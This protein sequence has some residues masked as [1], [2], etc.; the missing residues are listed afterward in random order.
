MTPLIT[1]F[2][3]PKPSTG[4]IAVLQTNAVSS[5]RRLGQHVV[6]Y[7]DEAGVAELAASTDAEHVPE[8]T[9]NEHDTPL[10]DGI[11]EDAQARARSPIVCFANAD[12][13]L[14]PEFSSA[15]ARVSTRSR[16]FL[17]IG[18]S[19]DTDV[20]ELVDF[21]TEW[22]QGLLARP[23]RR[24]GAGA[25]DYFAFTR[26]L[27]DRLPPF[28]VGRVAFDNWLV[29]RARDIGAMVVDAS[30]SVRAIHQRHDYG[31]A[32][33]GF[34]GTRYFSDEGQ[35]NLDLAGGKAF[36]YTRC[37]ATHVLGPRLLRPNLGRPFRAKERARKAVYKARRSAADA[38]LRR[39]AHERA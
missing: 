33:G 23:G 32:A 3:V 35:R 10:L 16:A 27:Y 31:H 25:I 9:R 24:R 28:A 17:M 22:E 5:W 20:T 2:S 18:E 8:V 13:I 26:G 12:I 29:W 36:L 30:P 37:D 19:W 38:A 7:G 34:A 39:S 11:F 1:F 21:E 6:L 4:R 15:I 14:P